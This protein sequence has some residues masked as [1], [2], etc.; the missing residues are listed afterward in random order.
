MKTIVILLSFPLLL[1]LPSNSSGQ[2]QR[3]QIEF[4][5]LFRAVQQDLPRERIYLHT[6][7][8]WY[9]VGDRVW[10]SAYLTAGQGNL[11]S[12][13][14]GVLYVEL[15]D[16]DGTVLER[17]P[18]KVEDG[19]AEA[20]LLLAD[21]NM[22]TGTYLLKAYSAWSLNFGPSYTFSKPIDIANLEQEA[23]NNESTEGVANVQFLPESGRLVQGIESVVGVKAV[24][25]DGLGV[26][27][28]GRIVDGQ[29]NEVTRFQTEHKGM[30]SFVITPESGS[31][32]SAIVNGVTYNLP[33]VRTQ[34]S[35]MRITEQDGGY[36]A[37]VQSGGEDQTFLLFGHVRGE[38]YYAAPV[39]LESGRG[40]AFLSQEMFPTGII[41][42]TLLNQ[43]G[44]P[45]AERLVFNKNSEDVQEVRI[46]I[47]E[48]IARR[49]QAQLSL[50]V[51]QTDGTR[52]PA[53][54]SVAVFD[55]RISTFNEYRGSIV[56]QLFL[57]SELRGYIEQPGYYFE[58]NEDRSRELDLLM[59]TQGW[60]SYNME[61][62]VNFEGVDLFSMPE[63]GLI[64]SGSVQS[65]F[66]RN[67][68]V[69]A[70]VMI[71]T[72][73]SESDDVVITTTVED[74][75]FSVTGF[76]FY[77]NQPINIRATRQGSNDNVHV[78]IDPQFEY[79]PENRLKSNPHLFSFSLEDRDVEEDVMPPL[80]ER[81]E[82][83]QITSER[84]VEFQMSGELEEVVVTADRLREDQFERDLRFSGGQSQSLD[85]DEEPHLRDLPVSS[86]L[87]RMAGVR[88]D[89]TS[90]ILINTG[91]SSFGGTP[92][93]LIIIDGVETTPDQLL[94]LT[95]TDIQSINVFRRAADLAL[96]GVEA[97]GGVLYVRT[98][99][100]GGVIEQR[101]LF[102]EIFQGY[103]RAAEFYSPEYGISVP[104]DHDAV[105]DRITLYWNPIVDLTD[106]SGQVRFFGNDVPSTYRIVVEGITETGLPFYRTKTVDIISEN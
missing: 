18:V 88:V 37:R 75:I 54:A 68:I 74:G 6:D 61:E 40:F 92:D 90:R 5:Q 89:P 87:N 51:E 10:M 86:V 98:R 62:L 96:F 29:G 36:S 84:F 3:A 24:G 69:D 76:H 2:D 97:A 55:D 32:Y 63:T 66:R 103:Q 72:G 64:I 9:L 53:S 43:Q 67:P 22:K 11:L 100:G 38:V 106:G 80:A 47:P 17:F 102:T 27:I 4:L 44:L 56:S 48:T 34:G 25:S 42:L 93:P 16:E 7:R 15:I 105:D 99:R 21:Q 104:R 101:G 33:T 77:G 12:G 41:H 23:P 70:N 26:D 78:N 59:L 13:I 50:T 60:R 81:S 85:L 82:N 52:V 95:S 20:S 45:V 79:L 14:S 39:E 35:T 46:D 31:T 57:E 19:R 91:G 94:Q 28:E 8:D 71:S 58:L 83:A 30:G 49:D 1:A 73:L 65:Q